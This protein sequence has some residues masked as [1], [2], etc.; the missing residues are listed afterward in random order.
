MATGSVN[1]LGL[2]HLIFI[3]IGFLCHLQA[4]CMHTAQPRVQKTRPVS[5]QLS[6][7]CMCVLLLFLLFINAGRVARCESRFVFIIIFSPI[8]VVQGTCI[9][10]IVRACQAV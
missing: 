7:K 2:K 1:S 10:Y 6:F 4:V 8:L 3:H 5:P 9:I